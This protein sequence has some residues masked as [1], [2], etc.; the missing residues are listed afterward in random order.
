M[1]TNIG[2]FEMLALRIMA[3]DKL[4]D[5]DSNAASLFKRRSMTFCMCVCLYDQNQ[6]CIERQDC[7]NCS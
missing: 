2:R 7:I 6:H 4:K 5:D 1:D 3:G